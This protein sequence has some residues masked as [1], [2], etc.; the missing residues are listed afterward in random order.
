MIEDIVRSFADEFGFEF[1]KDDG[2]YFVESATHGVATVNENG[3]DCDSQILKSQLEKWI[4]T[5]KSD[6]P[7]EEPAVLHNPT[8]PPVSGF[9][10]AKR[11]KRKL[12]LALTGPSGSGKTVSALLIARGMTDSWSKIGLI[13]TESGS[14][15]LYT[16]ETIGDTTIGSYNVYTLD[17]PFTPQRYMDAMKAA[18]EAGFEVVIIDSLSHAW[19]GE[20]GVLE[21]HGAETEA[22]KSKNSYFAWKNIT[23]LHRKL[24]EQIKSSEIH[25]IVTMRSKTEYV[26]GDRNQPL[27]VGMSPIQRGGT[28]YE[29]DVVF[30]MSQSHYTLVSKTRTSIFDNQSFIPTVETGQKL[31]GWVEMET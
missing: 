4:A 23:P 8:S 3:V 15:D 26:I 2:S 31:L 27:K 24:I 1:R 10:P 11:S 30:D 5:N 22:S 14:G 9:R 7:F 19:E 25:V 13:D 12:K 29:F 18:G 17:P 6:A 20:G 16:G 28:E 21:M